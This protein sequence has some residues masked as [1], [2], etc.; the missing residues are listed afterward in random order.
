MVTSQEVVRNQAV[1]FANAV[2]PRGCDC[3]N[4]GDYCEWCKAY[5]NYLEEDEDWRREVRG[6]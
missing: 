5:H 6:Q 1:E 2:Q 4:N 3:L